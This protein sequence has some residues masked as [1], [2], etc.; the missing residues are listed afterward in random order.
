[1]KD[2]IEAS[3]PLILLVFLACAF[4]LGAAVLGVAYLR[5]FLQAME[6]LTFKIG[7]ALVY[8]ALMAT[9]CAL[10]ALFINK[11]MISVNWRWFFS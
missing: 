7:F 2:K 8:I 9:A 5:V 11:V 6:G 3:A 1:M 4:W 10:V